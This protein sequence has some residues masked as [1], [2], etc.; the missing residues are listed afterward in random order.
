LGKKHET[1]DGGGPPDDA[2]AK[3]EVERLTALPVSD[4]AGEILSAFAPTAQF[5]EHRSRV[6]Y[7]TASEVRDLLI[8]PFSDGRTYLQMQRDGM[9]YLDDLG[10]AAREALQ[11]LEHASLVTQ[12]IHGSGGSRGYETGF[13][14]TRRGE[15][16]LAEGD[17][18]RYL[19]GGLQT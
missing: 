19:G 12:D 6:R 7:R 10:R 2:A 11:A 4:L 13:S 14:I 5:P 15:S 17:V 8:E 9:T 3:A 1:N 18:H 16:A